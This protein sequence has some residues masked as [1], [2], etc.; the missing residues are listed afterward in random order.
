M[1]PKIKQGNSSHDSSA[2][3]LGCRFLLGPILSFHTG[4]KVE[5]NLLTFKPGL[6]LQVSART[7][8]SAESEWHDI[9]TKD[10]K[11]SFCQTNEVVFHPHIHTGA[12]CS[13]IDHI[14]SAQ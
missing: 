9:S 8:F 4:H 7:A 1:K 3:P 5:Q 2:A 10:P 13:P 12:S 11:I 6:N 14:P